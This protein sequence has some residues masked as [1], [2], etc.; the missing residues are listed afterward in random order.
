MRERERG[1]ELERALRELDH[2]RYLRVVTAILYVFSEEYLPLYRETF[3]T[4]CEETLDEIR[5]ACLGHVDVGQLKRLW[6]KWRA[7][8][9]SDGPEDVTVGSGGYITVLSGVI[10]ELLYPR[11]AFFL[12]PYIVNPIHVPTPEELRAAHDAAFYL[13]EVSTFEEDPR[14]ERI[15]GRIERIVALSGASEDPRD[16]ARSSAA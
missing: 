4:F 16:I 13:L 5:R 14:S 6:R 15:M 1:E 8:S 2:E 3:R 10:D 7:Y 11:A 12:V 9:D